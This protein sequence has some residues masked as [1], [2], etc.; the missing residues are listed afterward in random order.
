MRSNATCG[1]ASAR[2]GGGGRGEG[3]GGA[4]LLLDLGELEAHELVVRV[5][6]RVHVREDLERLGLAAVVDQPPRGLGEP[7]CAG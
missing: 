3:G 7:D 6:V 1:A 4:D 5:A 2:A